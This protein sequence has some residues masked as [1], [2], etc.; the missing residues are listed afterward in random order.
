MWFTRWV[1]SFTS[2]TEQL[3]A[4]DVRDVMAAIFDKAAH[5]ID[6]YGAHRQPLG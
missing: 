1:S 2:M 5:I 4:E 6:R 3:E